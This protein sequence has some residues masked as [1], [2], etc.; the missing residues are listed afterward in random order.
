MKVKEL[1]AD[2]FRWTHKCMARDKWG[3][4]VAVDSPRAV[5]FC[6]MGAVDK[7]YPEWEENRAVRK[8]I[9]TRVTIMTTFNDLEG[10]KAVK[11]LVDT[12][13]I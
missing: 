3:H 13:D 2:R 6:L 4:S 8:K 11:S 9:Y 5:K 1:L 7:C 10:Y 12:L